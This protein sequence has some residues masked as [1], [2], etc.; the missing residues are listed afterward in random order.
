MKQFTALVSMVFF[1]SFL[2][3]QSASAKPNKPI[4]DS[5]RVQVA[6]LLDVSGSMDG[7]IEQAKSQLWGMMQTLSKA[8]RDGK[9]PIVE[10][11]LY[12]YG[13]PENGQANNYIKRIMPFTTDLDVLSAKL[14]EL[15]T[16]GGDEYCGAVL[17]QSLNELEWGGGQEDYKV[18]FIAGNESFKQGNIPFAQACILAKQKGVVINTVY[19]GDSLTGIKEYWGQNGECGNGTY[20][21]INQNDQE[22]DKPAPQDSMI[23]VLN[24]KLNT[25]Y[26]T[27]N[28]AGLGRAQLQRQMDAANSAAKKKAGMQRAAVKAN[29][30][31]YR[32]SNWD[33]VDAYEE[34]TTVIEKLDKAYLPDTLKNKSKAEIKKYVQV[35]TAERAAIQQQL[36]DLLK[37]RAA[38]LAAEKLRESGSNNPR[39]LDN[40][41][42]S[43]LR[44]QAEL[45]KFSFVE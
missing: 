3:F 25:S 30:E 41:V 22:D 9:K 24:E 40:A 6:I 21:F 13:R 19:C 32:N 42:Q 5:A 2:S 39:D 45:R 43:I 27:Y 15:K 16:S 28:T 18:I 33:L 17:V 36:N 38:Y 44:K 34:D 37:Q 12:E 23:L 20:A 8:T 4:T 10:I 31:A 1:C 29:K 7:L 35:K 11:A 26:V 14:F